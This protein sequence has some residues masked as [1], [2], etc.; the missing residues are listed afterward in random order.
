M[1]DPR[2]ITKYDEVNYLALTFKIDNSTIT[3]DSTKEGGSS[4]VGYAVT[5][6]GQADDTVAL[7]GDGEK[8]TGKLITVS[9]DLFCAVQVQ[10]GMTLPGGTSATLT[11]GSS[12][13]GDLGGV[14]TTDKGYIQTGTTAGVARGSIVNNDT[15]TA[16]VVVL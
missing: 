15:T 12:I 9:K 10:G 3:Y 13:V 16:V 8:V 2:K 5:L 4:Q 1:A 7:V 6:T 11:I 14:S